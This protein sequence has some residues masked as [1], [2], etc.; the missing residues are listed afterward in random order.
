MKKRTW[1]PEM[2]D[3]ELRVHIQ[4]HI[5]KFKKFDEWVEQSRKV[6]REL[7]DTVIDI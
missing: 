1:F 6:S 5:R 3:E 4:E 7:L 2:T